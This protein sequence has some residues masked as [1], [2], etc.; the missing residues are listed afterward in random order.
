MAFFPAILMMARFV[1]NNNDKHYY[2][3][4]VPKNNNK[5]RVAKVKTESKPQSQMKRI[6]KQTRF[7]DSFAC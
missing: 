1:A 5:K 6:K 2:T 3:F 7:N 4:L